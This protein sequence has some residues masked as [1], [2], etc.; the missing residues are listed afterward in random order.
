MSVIIRTQI[1]HVQLVSQIKSNMRP[2][3]EH[4]VRIKLCCMQSEECVCEYQEVKYQLC[5]I[6]KEKYPGLE[7]MLY[8]EPVLTRCNTSFHVRY[9]DKYFEP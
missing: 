7:P 8:P 1:V 4:F 9:L 2:V 5:H 6:F 3:T